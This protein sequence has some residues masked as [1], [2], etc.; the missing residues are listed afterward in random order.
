MSAEKFTQIGD[1]A[2]KNWECHQVSRQSAFEIPDSTWCSVHLECI[3]P[4]LEQVFVLDLGVAETE[5]V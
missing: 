1:L 4:P 2:F 3:Y 5:E